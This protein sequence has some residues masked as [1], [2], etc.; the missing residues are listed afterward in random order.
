MDRK[1]AR[2]HEV[3]LRLDDKEY[4]ALEKN[5]K[6]CKLSQQAY[7][8]KLCENVVPQEAPSA[9]F[10]TCIN[11]LQ[12]IGINMNQIAYEAHVNKF[13]NWDYYR[14]N[15][16]DLWRAENEL[17]ASIM[18]PKLAHKDLLAALLEKHTPHEEKQA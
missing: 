11:Q 14:K 15:A 5:R 18:Y 8:R 9:D 10:F 1:R 6:K 2:T 17:F 12:R 16:D 13:V 4:A 7:L 3:H